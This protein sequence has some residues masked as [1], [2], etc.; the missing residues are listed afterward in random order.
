MFLWDDDQ[1][2]RAAVKP[3]SIGHVLPLHRIQDPRVLRVEHVVLVAAEAAV[4][5]AHDGGVAF[6]GVLFERVAE[7]AQRLPW[8][9]AGRWVGQRLVRPEAE[10]GVGQLFPR[11]AVTRITLAGGGAGGMGDEGAA[12]AGVERV[13]VGEAEAQREGGGRG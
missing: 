7:Q 11:K 13:S 12:R 5:G 2:Q 9:E 10:A 4:E 1:E 8:V 6:A 3:T